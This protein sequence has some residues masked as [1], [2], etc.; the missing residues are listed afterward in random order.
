MGTG[1]GDGGTEGLGN[2]TYS[3]TWISGTGSGYGWELWCLNAGDRQ[4]KNMDLE[5]EMT[6]II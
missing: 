1:W 6:L 2:I 3:W 5:R 4:E